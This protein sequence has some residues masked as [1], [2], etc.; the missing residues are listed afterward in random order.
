MSNLSS[1]YESAVEDLLSDAEDKEAKATVSY[2]E[3]KIW[4]QI[5][6]I[7]TVLG[8]KAALRS[9]HIDE[10]RALY[11]FTGVEPPLSLRSSSE[12][13]EVNEKLQCLKSLVGIK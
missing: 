6:A 2:T 5:S 4:E 7:R 3:E 9:S 11:V 13:T 1:C 12:L 10:L 8:Y